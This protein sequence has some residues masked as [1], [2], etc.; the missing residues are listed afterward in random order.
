MPYVRFLLAGF[1]ASLCVTSGSCTYEYE[2]LPSLNEEV[3]YVRNYFYVGG[4]YVEDGYGG[5]AFQDQM[6][7]E[8]LTPLGGPKKQTPLV[9]IPGAG[10]TGTVY[11]I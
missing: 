1:F 5:H 11:S 8:R 9:F 4:R 10:Q 2:D 7:V 6:Y 3:P